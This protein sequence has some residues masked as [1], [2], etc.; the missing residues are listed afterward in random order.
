MNWG[1]DNFGDRELYDTYR[2]HVTGY[3]IDDRTRQNFQPKP[4]ILQQLREQ[5]VDDFN[6]KKV[7]F[8]D[9]ISL[10]GRSVETALL[11]FEKA[12]PHMKEAEAVSYFTQSQV[13][14]VMLEIGDDGDIKPYWVNRTLMPW[15]KNPGLIGVIDSAKNDDVLATSLTKDR[16]VSNSAYA[17]QQA[18]D[19]LYNLE[20]FMEQHEREIEQVIHE[21]NKFR[22]TY[23]LESFRCLSE[24]TSA[25][26]FFQR[27]A[28]I[29]DFADSLRKEADK[30]SGFYRSRWG[31]IYTNFDVQR[32]DWLFN[33]SSNLKGLSDEII[34]MKRAFG[35]TQAMRNTIEKFQTLAQDIQRRAHDA[36]I[37][38]IRSKE[39]HEMEENFGKAKQLRKE[40]KKLASENIEDYR[41]SRTD[42]D[43]QN[44]ETTMDRPHLRLNIGNDW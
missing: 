41:N 38:Q 15:F 13:D 42:D 39:I 32:R 30:G 33:A 37:A 12:F 43:D 26:R 40:M 20:T 22:G 19:T 6:D 36:F 27:R 18:E 11:L 16:L 35:R 25:L 2:T 14:P 29:K 34:K 10:S 44:R 17:E 31:R 3:D 5:F 8:V 24:L 4:E 28:E 1:G 9:E 21:F 23:D 7:L